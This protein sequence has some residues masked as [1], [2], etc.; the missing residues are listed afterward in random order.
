MFL[1]PAVMNYFF[2]ALFAQLRQNATEE[3]MNGKD[4][5]TQME[6]WGEKNA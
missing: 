2:K 6:L 5:P 4:S 1:D 3:K